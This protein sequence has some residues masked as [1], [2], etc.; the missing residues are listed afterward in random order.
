MVGF[1][2]CSLPT[3]APPYQFFQL[4][5]S[6]HQLLSLARQLG[7]HFLQS[8]FS[9]LQSQE[10]CLPSLFTLVLR[11]SLPLHSPESAWTAVTCVPAY[12]GFVVSSVG[13]VELMGP[14]MRDIH[15]KATMNTLSG[16]AIC[17]SLILTIAMQFV[18]CGVKERLR[19]EGIAVND[20]VILFAVGVSRLELR[21]RFGES[22]SII[23][24]V[25][26][27][28]CTVYPKD[29]AASAFFKQ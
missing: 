9:F 23:I 29:Q 15:L 14:L 13:D 25:G 1:L 3:N 17:M 21:V 12:G 28:N 6:H 20:K 16:E 2:V 19:Q 22:L 5:Y 27:K 7:T 24:Q 11:Y 10:L 4:Q 26:L 18:Y 8:S